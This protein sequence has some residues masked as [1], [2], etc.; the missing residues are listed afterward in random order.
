MA[1]AVGPWNQFQASPGPW[2]Q[3]KAESPATGPWTQF[4]QKSEV[5]TDP[6]E[7]AMQA[8]MQQGMSQGPGSLVPKSPGLTESLINAVGTLGGVGPLTSGSAG[9][10]V[11][12][13]EQ[14]PAGLQAAIGLGEKIYGGITGLFNPHS[15]AAAEAKKQQ[16]EFAQSDVSKALTPRTEAG[17]SMAAF[18][19]SAIGQ[20]QQAL[21]DPQFQEK[22]L[23][24]EIAHGP[25]GAGIA[26]FAEMAP[27]L[28]I[29][30]G[31]KAGVSE[32]TKT[33]TVDTIQPGK[34]VPTTPTDTWKEEVQSQFPP[35]SS[36]EITGRQFGGQNPPEVTEQ[37]MAGVSNES[38]GP[39]FYKEVLDH[40]ELKHAVQF[41]LDTEEI[42][43]E[44][45]KTAN[46][47]ELPHLIAD[48][49]NHVDRLA[50]ELR[51]YGITSK[52]DAQG[53][54]V[55][56][57][58]S[59]RVWDELNFK[60]AEQDSRAFTEKLATDGTRTVD[61]GLEVPSKFDEING[62]Y[63]DQV[64]PISA[65]GKAVPV[66]DTGGLVRIRQTLDI[67]A[68]L[69]HI[70]A[71]TQN[72]LFKTLATALRNFDLMGSKFGVTMN[73]ATD[74]KGKVMFGADTSG[75]QAANYGIGTK[76]VTIGMRGLT[77]RVFLHE[78]VHSVTLRAML[79]A[80]KNPLLALQGKTDWAV[81]EGHPLAPH[82]K[83]IVNAWK[84]LSDLA[85]EHHPEAFA[86]RH[87]GSWLYGLV[88]PGELMAE[89]GT[90]QKFMSWLNHQVILENGKPTTILGKVRS[91][92]LGILGK[93]ITNSALDHVMFHTSELANAYAQAPKLW[94]EFFERQVKSEFSPLRPDPTAA[95]IR[96][97]P[98]LEKTDWIPDPEP[99]EIAKPKIL[100]E[101]DGG[102]QITG[103]ES[104]LGRG[105]K[106]TQN[107]MGPKVVPGSIM[108]SALRGSTLVDNI[109]RIMTSAVK[110]ADAAAEKWTDPIKHAISKLKE[111]ARS[112]LQSVLM[113]ELQQKARYT[114]DQLRQLG[115]NDAQIRAYTALRTSFD[116]SLKRQNEVRAEYK[117]KPI[118]ELDAYHAARFQ[119]G[120]FRA[121]F[122]DGTGKKIWG[123]SEKTPYD[124]QK[125]INWIQKNHPELKLANLKKVDIGQHFNSLQA[126]YLEMLDFLDKDDPRTQA[127]K[128]TYEEMLGTKTENVAGQERHFQVKSGVRGYLGDRP[129]VQ[130]NASEFFEEQL[131]YLEGA[132]KWTEMQKAFSDA[133]KYTG[134][135][136]IRTAQ[137]NNVAYA[138]EYVKHTMGFGSSKLMAELE[139]KVAGAFGQSPQT[140]MNG[141][142]FGKKYFY[143]LELSW[144]FPFMMISLAQH[145]FAMAQHAM[146]DSEGFTSKSSQYLFDGF[147]YGTQ[148]ALLD[149]KDGALSANP[150]IPGMDL[151]E[152]MKGFWA[153]AREYAHANKIMDQNPLLEAQDIKSGPIQHKIEQI[154]NF[155]TASVEKLA[156]GWTFYG[157]VSHLADSGKFDLKDPASLKEMFYKA[158]KGV[159]VTMGD[160]RPTE[161]SMIFN[162]MGMMGKMAAALK[163]Y[164][165]NYMGQLMLY[166]KEANKG[167]YKPLAWF[168]AMQFTVG[169]ARG[170][171]AVDEIE[172]IWDF[173]KRHM[174]SGLYEHVKDYSP[175]KWMA[176]PANMSDFMYHG[177]LSKLT[178]LNIDVQGS[179]GRLIPGLQ[180]GLNAIGRH[181]IEYG[182]LAD[183]AAQYFPSI[184]ENLE[185][186][187]A[188]YGTAVGTALKNTPAW[189]PKMTPNETAEHL[190]EA[191]PTGAKG[192]LREK[193]SDFHK[194]DLMM[195]PHELEKGQYIRNQSEH[196]KGEWG[197]KSPQEQRA[198]DASHSYRQ[199]LAIMNEHRK[200][201]IRD[202]EE[203]AL[204]KDTAQI[205]R[206]A[207]LYYQLGG[208]IAELDKDLSKAAIEKMTDMRQKAAF[209][210]LH[211]TNLTKLQQSR[212]FLQ[213][214]VPQK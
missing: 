87:N 59:D 179:M 90:N 99:F 106:E 31:I 34:D 116:D 200:E 61:P 151:I 155:P 114:P 205:Q 23:G 123:I 35:G 69:D 39:G 126:G 184:H 145:G 189:V 204:R 100:K 118:T 30:Y 17:Q 192:L 202:L 128:S 165:T 172:A 5:P 159:S 1:E 109:S 73:I 111:D 181:N 63:P 36:G 135:K 104:R 196:T 147:K 12:L 48:H 141:M 14:I 207:P 182:Q 49:D 21:Q 68:T 164:P 131:K 9:S 133:T 95:A 86:D 40:P 132:A 74:Q 186:A 193:D 56:D 16:E 2:S 125:A 94:D 58:I 121:D 45:A 32:R 64:I 203:Y 80:I 11:G 162:Q 20:G 13:A 26:A 209:D 198:I 37:G 75:R 115:M 62:Q 27:D 112:E 137:P 146:L 91:A 208:N 120:S 67:N 72:P 142:S 79:G 201:V 148:H 55:H 113:K 38:I 76:Q 57:M 214:L 105:L 136:E 81:N 180:E 190:Y 85:Q 33:S 6:N 46:E 7:A 152:P 191:T 84:Q 60:W 130:K 119:T 28:A 3:F 71:N 129:W 176:N 154:G 70:I 78:M 51:A 103:E 170:M 161:R 160:Y 183:A 18:V 173:M 98:G 149:A 178:G 43:N 167:N 77:E 52:A 101:Q 177:L 175:K 187:K 158:E 66:A 144:K 82:I 124:R 197:F 169:G 89:V 210:L 102:A 157:L 156:R 92:F 185:T 122:V 194:G 174:P 47:E 19:G 29:A 188:V 97:L 166:T 199:M 42:L 41:A 143:I 108:S 134:D 150:N 96:G 107:T 138:E 65:L 24:K 15:T 212:E 139:R 211:E 140:F 4:A 88:N 153:N 8:K 83:A 206:L 10:P 50:S 195:N 171:V 25:V 168:L 44:R 117:L 163:T 127:L 53:L 110:R 22:Y 213:S 54:A 93:E